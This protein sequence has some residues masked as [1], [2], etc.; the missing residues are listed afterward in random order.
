M[1]MEDGDGGWRMEGWMTEDGGQRMEDRGWRMREDGGRRMEDG[2]W[3][4]EAGG[5]GME[6]L[7]TVRLS[8]F[9]TFRLSNK[10][11]DIKLR[12]LIIS[13]E[14]YISEISQIIS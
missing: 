12:Y 10:R 6:D 11:Y 13:H 8:D 4:M 9:Q 1:E 14:T 2:G 3:R 5:Y 7:Q